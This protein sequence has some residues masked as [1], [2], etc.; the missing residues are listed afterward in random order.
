M[1]NVRPLV[2]VI[3]PTYNR[4]SHLVEC[5]KRVREQTYPNLEH[6]IVH[7]GPDPELYF[8]EGLHGKRNERH[9]LIIPLDLA[10]N[11][12]TTLHNSFGIAP[13]LAGMLLSNGVY[14][15]WLSDDD[16][17]DK[18]YIE[19]LVQ[20][21]ERENVDFVY[22][23]CWFYWHD[24]VISEGYEIGVEPPQHGQITNFLYKKSI[25]YRPGFMPQFGTHP[26]DWAL[27]NQWVQGGASYKMLDEVK[28]YHRA[29]Q[30]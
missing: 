14:Q 20:L 18:D 27:V 12:S 4:Q 9:V 28:F 24:Q 25:L 19:K 10:W 13:L 16:H 29:D 21:I 30:R 22:S 8:L 15:I 5:A 3:T 17:M 6:V 26:V 7:D 23:K 11:T 2:S 1:N